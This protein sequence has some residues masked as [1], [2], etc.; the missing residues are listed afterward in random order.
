MGDPK[1]LRR[2]Y[3]T[4]KHP[5][6]A[7]RM[8]EERKLLDRYGL[9]NKREL[10]KAQSILRGFRQQARDL[11]A[12]AQDGGRTGATRDRPAARPPRPPRGPS[13]GLPD[14]GRRSR[15]DDRGPPEAPA[16]SG[17]SFTR[18]LAPTPKGAR[19][20][21]RPR[22]FLHRRPPR[23]PPRLPRAVR[24]R[25]ADRVHAHQPARERGPR[26][27]GSALRE[28]LEAPS[29]PVAAEPPRARGGLGHGEDRDRAHLRELQQHPHHG[30]RHHRRRDA[31]EGDRRDGREGGPRRIEPVRGDEGRRPG[32]RA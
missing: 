29:A 24:R 22:P 28:R 23:H 19:Q 1:F 21:D 7:G 20:V 11:Q 12:R 15:P 4:P 18:G 27:S 6:E 26:R 32:R 17:S 9:K 10:W 31:R 3:D 13:R 25:G 8:E 2:T 16:S 30:H 5:W 14:T